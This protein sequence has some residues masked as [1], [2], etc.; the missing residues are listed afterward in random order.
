MARFA[1]LLQEAENDLIE[2]WQYIARDDPDAATRVL[3][4]LDEKFV[5]S[6]K[7]ASLALQG[8]TLRRIC[9]IWL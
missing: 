8:P 5:C 6:L 9:D 7:T 3:R 1:L 2:I 4:S